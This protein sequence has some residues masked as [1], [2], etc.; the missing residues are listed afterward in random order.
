VQV[1]LQGVYK[2]LAGYYRVWSAGNANWL[3]AERALVAQIRGGVNAEIARIKANGEDKVK[4]N[5][6]ADLNLLVQMLT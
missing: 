6:L 4:L 2:S 3:A 1:N 5:Y